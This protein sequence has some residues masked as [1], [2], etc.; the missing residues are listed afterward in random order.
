MNTDY[1]LSEVANSLADEVDALDTTADEP[2]DAAPEETT[3]EGGLYGGDDTETN[4]EEATER[5]DVDTDATSDTE[6]EESPSD[7]GE[8]DGRPVEEQQEPEAKEKQRTFTEE[9]LMAE[10]ERRGLKVAEKKDEELE[11]EPEPAFSRPDEVP[12]DVW[13]GMSDLYKEIYSNLP[14]LEIRSK[15]GQVLKI[16]TDDQVPDGFEFESE[17]AKRRFYSSEIPAQSVRAE[18]MA[19]RYKDRNEHIRITKET[20]AAQEEFNRGVKALQEQGILPDIPRGLAKH[21]LDQHPGVVLGNRI[22]DLQ[23]QHME[24]GEYLTLE[25]AGQLYKGLHPEEFNTRKVEDQLTEADRTRVA[26]QSS[27]RGSAPVSSEPKSGKPR[28]K[29][30]PGM[31][32]TEIADYYAEDLD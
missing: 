26:S 30:R 16:K 1:S 4:T 14:Y 18:S 13:D 5:E 9:E 17:E 20:A 10:L 2:V 27:N 21:E 25:T 24:R 32:L 22:L 6:A 28:L 31:S 11:K 23:R 7:E 12:A 8:R 3:G 19:L 29:Y 15:D